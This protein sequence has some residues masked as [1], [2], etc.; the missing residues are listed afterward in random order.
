MKALSNVNVDAAALADAAANLK[1]AIMSIET[2]KAML[3]QKYQQLGNGWN[4]K[5]YKELGD[6]VQECIHA[7]ISIEKNLLQGERYTA[8][9]IKYIQEYENINLSGNKNVSFSNYFSHAIQAIR[10]PT[11]TQ[12]R[13]RLNAVGVKNVNLAGIPAQVQEAIATSFESMSTIFPES[14]GCIDT[15]AI[16]LNMEDSTPAS[17]GYRMNDGC[18][19][20]QMNINPHWFSNPNLNNMINE[21]S[22]DGLWAGAGLSGIINHEIAHAMHLQLDAE[23]LGIRFGETSDNAFLYSRELSNRWSYNTTT[24]NIRDTVLNSMGLSR[25]DVRNMISIYADT[26]GSECFAECVAD[27]TTSSSP[28]QLSINIIQEYSRRLNAI[29]NGGHNI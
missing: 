23:E 6:I 29:R 1:N 20:T 27:Y 15:I 19:R 7:L 14:R 16:S 8:I 25:D 13:S 3:K 2:T 4:D 12:V 17:T 24:D 11:L 22:D 5:K 9:L 26:D 28:N 18:L 21:C 10:N